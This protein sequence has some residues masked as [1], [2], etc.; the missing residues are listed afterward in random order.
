MGYV[1]ID[2]EFNNLKNI[3]KY[4]EDFF[5]KHKELENINLENEIIEIGAIK[6]DK[7]MKQVAEMREYIKPSVF[8][9]MNP[10]VTN[11]TKI[12]M[13]TLQKE[14]ITFKQGMDKLKGMIEDGDVICSWAKDDIAEIIINS[15]YHNYTDLSWIKEYLDLQEYSTK[16]LGHKKAMGLKSAL[17]EL[18]IKVDNTKLHDA[19]NDAEYTLLVFKHIYNSRIVKNYIINDIY[20][21]PAIHVKDLDNINIDEE[22][23]DIRCPKCN[24]KIDLKENFKLLNWRFVSIGICPKCNSKI[25]S[26]LIVKRTLQGKNAY[27][28]VNTIL[29]E[30]AYLDYYYKLE[31]LNSQ[32]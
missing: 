25:L 30:E 26:E 28:E 27:N 22:K 29:K 23:L 13:D 1:I 9:V 7:Y 20:S 2:L 6:V 10:I 18:K 5:D 3:T 32:K 11:I 24:K 15:N 19:L 17:D 8:P 12:T 21:M 4:K 31:K 14:G 16:I